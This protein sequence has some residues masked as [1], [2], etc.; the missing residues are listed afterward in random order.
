[1]L[2]IRINTNALKK[3]THQ[4]VKPI[5]N[6]VA[7]EKIKKAALEAQSKMIANFENHLVTKE[8]ESG[9]DGYN[10]SGTLSGYGNLYS[11][12]GF[13][14]GMDPIT[15]IRRILQKSLEIK[16]LPSG[17]RSM[18]TNFLVELPS[19]QEIIEAS[20]MPWAEGRSWVEGI[21]KGISGLGQYLNKVSFSSRSGE[22]VQSENKIRGGG[23]KNSKYLSDILNQLNRDIR[24]YI[25]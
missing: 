15:P 1:V 6:K 19:K 14:E 22:G 21:E 3:I 18:I 20:P 5:V 2:K 8:I 23:F 11:F 25:K 12:I 10:M 24:K 17:A 7:Y 9:P 16:S 4:Q 13:E